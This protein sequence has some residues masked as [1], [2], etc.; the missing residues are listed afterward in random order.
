MQ[1]LE[2]QPE[3]DG[4]GQCQVRLLTSNNVASENL[5]RL[6]YV[7]PKFGQGSEERFTRVGRVAAPSQGPAHVKS[8]DIPRSVPSV[9]CRGFVEAR[10]MPATVA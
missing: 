5:A 6:P 9:A 2:I 10:K 1:L 4:Q 3:Q 7:L 8:R